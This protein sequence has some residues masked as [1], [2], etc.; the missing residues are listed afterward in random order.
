MLGLNKWNYS[1]WQYQILAISYVQLTENILLYVPFSDCTTYLLIVDI[2]YITKK[3]AL[4]FN[5]S[6]CCT[7]QM[8]PS[9]DGQLARWL[10]FSGKTWESG[11]ISPQVSSFF[12]TRK[13]TCTLEEVSC[14]NTFSLVLTLRDKILDKCNLSICFF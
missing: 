5:L 1:L 7:W 2:F 10:L 9:S 13:Y 6:G 11:I 3:E 14:Q 12:L 8:E 4:S